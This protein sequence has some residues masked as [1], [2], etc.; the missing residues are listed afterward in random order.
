[1]DQCTLA[2]AAMKRNEAVRLTLTL[3]HN[4]EAIAKRLGDEEFAEWK[5]FR[6]TKM[7]KGR[8]VTFRTFCDWVE[9]RVQA[10]PVEGQTSMMTTRALNP[11]ANSFTARQ[12]EP[13]E[14]FQ[15][16]TRHHSPQRQIQTEE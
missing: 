1:M 11:S 8:Q 9:I 16:Q 3:P 4:L 5:R 13:R 12:T 7:N 14:S 2:V 15:R 6:K 10:L